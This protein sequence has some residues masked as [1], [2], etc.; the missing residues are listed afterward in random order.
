M[1]R[2]N[3][4]KQILFKFQKIFDSFLEKLFLWGCICNRFLES[5]LFFQIVVDCSEP[6]YFLL[7]TMEFFLTFLLTFLKLFNISLFSASTV[8]CWYPILSE[9]LFLTCCWITLWPSAAALFLFIFM[10]VIY[11]SPRCSYRYIEFN[12]L[13]LPICWALGS[14]PHFGWLG[15]ELASV[16]IPQNS[17]LLMIWR[18]FFWPCR[19]LIFPWRSSTSGVLFL[20]H[21]SLE[22]LSIAV[23][24]VLRRTLPATT[25]QCVTLLLLK[26]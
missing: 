21:L 19:L 24:W 13:R 15:I 23:V 5:K 8:C 20:L 14:F 1:L 25:S 7:L 2:F 18:C 26:T 10:L 3:W 4:L 16:C 17:M 12:L 6:H 11:L 22:C 9:P